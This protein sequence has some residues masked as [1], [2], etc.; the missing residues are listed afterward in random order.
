MQ[1]YDYSIQYRNTKNHANADVLSRFSKQV[2]H[3]EDN[4][5]EEDVFQIFCEEPLLDAR[6]VAM[7]TAKGPFFKKI[8]LFIQEGW[9]RVFN[10][11]V[12]YHPEFKSLSDRREQLN[13]VVSRGAIALLYHLH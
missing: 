9:P 5:S 3:R 7:E 2:S 12:E 6:K 4:V 13:R 1:N 11:S 8:L 10:D